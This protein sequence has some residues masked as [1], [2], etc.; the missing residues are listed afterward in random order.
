MKLKSIQ[1]NTL[2]EE[3]F[4]ELLQAIVSGRLTPGEKTTMGEIARSLS[5]SIQPV[6]V[7]MR[8]LEVMSLVRIDS[9]KVII[10]KLNSDNLRE[11][12]EARLLMECYAA[13][14]AC[15]TRNEDTLITME[16]LIN[17]LE[18]AKDNEEY[19]RLSYEFH[20][21]IYNGVNNPIIISTI[22]SYWDRISP[23]RRLLVGQLN[24]S[25]RKKNIDYHRRMLEAMRSQNAAGVTKWLT[26]DLTQAMKRLIEMADKEGD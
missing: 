22:E 2:Q 9:R 15:E 16:K 23:Y 21:T 17:S 26:E 14:K 6:R 18:K 13:Q 8:K 5:V 7:A 25:D 10:S 11:L 24:S 4:D 3:V 19:R 12:L 20:F 1:R